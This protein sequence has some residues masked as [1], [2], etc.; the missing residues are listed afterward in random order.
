MQATASNSDLP[1]GLRRELGLD[2]FD[3]DTAASVRAE[4]RAAA[5]EPQYVPVDVDTLECMQQDAAGNCTSWTADVVDAA[6]AQS[7]STLN[8]VLLIG[9]VLLAVLFLI[10]GFSA[11][12]NRK[13][14]VV[15]TV[16]STGDED[17]YIFPQERAA[18]QAS[19]WPQLGDTTDGYTELTKHDELM[20]LLE[21][22]QQ[23]RAGKPMMLF[24]WDQGCGW[25]KRL[26]PN[27]VALADENRGDVAFVGM[28]YSTAPIEARRHFAKVFGP[29]PGIPRVVALKRDGSVAAMNGAATKENMQRFKD[30]L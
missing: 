19:P 6:E 25:C 28:H 29:V 3:G 21:A 20:T 1:P 22:P 27:F 23:Q 5:P 14:T 10:W 17:V 30:Q 12:F 15:V 16:S 9:A 24:V 26:R 13:G 4:L 18:L 7:R 11:L 2:G 8:I